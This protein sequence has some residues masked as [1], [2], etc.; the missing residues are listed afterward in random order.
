MVSRFLQLHFVI[1]AA[2]IANDAAH[3]LLHFGHR[4][5]AKNAQQVE[6]ADRKVCV[7]EQHLG[8]LAYLLSQVSTCSAAIILVNGHT[9]VRDQHLIKSLGTAEN[10]LGSCTWYQVEDPK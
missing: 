9:F 7:V 1:V 6:T 5:I 2:V 3:L 4:A 10:V 8:A